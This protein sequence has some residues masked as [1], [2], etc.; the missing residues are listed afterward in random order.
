MCLTLA[1][2]LLGA[3]G[4]QKLQNV[5]DE[6]EANQ[7]IDMLGQYNIRARKEEVGEGERKSFE[8]MING[9]E[10]T[11]AAAIQLMQ[12]HCLPQREKVPIEGGAIMT[13]LETEKAQDQ[14]RRTA[15]IESL[16]R[17][18]PGVTC[19]EVTFVLPEDRSI[20]LNPYQS[21]AT[22][23]INYK[24]PTFP[25]SEDKIK[26]MVAGSVPALKTENV[27]VL[28]TANPLRPLPENRMG[29]NFGRVALVGGIG[30]ATILTFVSIVFLLQ[31]KRRRQEPE[32]EQPA[33]TDND[34]PK[35][36]AQLD[37]G[38]DFDEDEEV[39]LP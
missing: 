28:L 35:Q 15:D 31:K 8:I 13:S 7:I 19:V 39:N 14:Q 26:S 25:H 36:A 23:V 37:D 38:Y 2:L 16:L 11:M 32:A 10:D 30:L 27:S 34:D 3:C 22:V 6:I 21:T 9:D 1:A 29:Y 5:K 24:T 18:L 17:T 20:A 12:E 33:A 4:G